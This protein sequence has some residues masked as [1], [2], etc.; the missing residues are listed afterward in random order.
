MNDNHVEKIRR[1]MICVNRIDGI[2]YKISKN[3]GIKENTL[4]LFY[5]LSD[6]R[7][8]T[9]KE[10]CD[11]WLI[12][13]TTINTVVRECVRDGYVRLQKSSHS[14][15]KEL[16]LTDTGQK[17]VGELMEELFRIENASY[18]VAREAFG[19]TFVEALHTF[20]NE[21]EARTSETGGG[22]IRKGVP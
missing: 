17:Y 13:R 11:E 18:A 1:I 14:K 21:L 10:I 2:Y 8:H 20:T 22:S 6:G 7:S 3:M 12:P 9:Q 4:S 15:E 5:A 19:D 16:I